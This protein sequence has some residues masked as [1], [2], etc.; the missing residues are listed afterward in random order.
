MCKNCMRTS[1]VETATEILA[2]SIGTSA[3]KILQ[4]LI[5]NNY[6]YDL[7]ALYIFWNWLSGRPIYYIYLYKI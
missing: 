4:Y 1:D 6:Y 7:N 3:I 2:L 5:H